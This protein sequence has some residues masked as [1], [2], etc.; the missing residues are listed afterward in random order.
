MSEMIDFYNNKFGPNTLVKMVNIGKRGQRSPE[1]TLQAAKEV[2]LTH[3]RKPYLND[4]T[5]GQMVHATARKFQREN[6][7]L[8]VDAWEF[9]EKLSRPRNFRQKLSNW[10][11]WGKWE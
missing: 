10:M 2:Y 11:Q 3:L 1:L 9:L 8:E 6:K 7:K 5:I 4:V